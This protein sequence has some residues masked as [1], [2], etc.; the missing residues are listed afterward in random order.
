MKLSVQR[1]M[2]VHVLEVGRYSTKKEAKRPML[3]KRE[4]DG[5]WMEKE[6]DE[7][8]KEIERTIV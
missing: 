5:G 1:S 8:K 4:E 2:Q 7:K 6:E 3:L